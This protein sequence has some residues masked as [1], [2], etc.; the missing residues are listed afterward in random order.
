MWNLFNHLLLLLQLSDELLLQVNL[1]VLKFSHGR[2]LLTR[3]TINWGYGSG[4]AL[5]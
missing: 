4:S 5:K 2:L 3:Q 1:L